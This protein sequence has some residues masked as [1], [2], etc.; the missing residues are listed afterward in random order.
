M[1]N[2][3]NEHKPVSGGGG[4]LKLKDGDLVNIRIV[5]EPV[6]FTNEYEGNL[7]TR[8]AWV[9]WNYDAD[10]A[11]VM[12]LPPSCYRQFY[13]LATGEWGDPAEY[14]V[15]IRR[16]GSGLE[17]KYYIQPKPKSRTLLDTQIE[18]AKSIDL[19]E[20]I[21]KSPSTSGVF[22]ISEVSD[23]DPI[24]PPKKSIDAE[25]LE[26]ANEAFPDPND[27]PVDM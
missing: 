7:S 20:Q 27:A 6:V 23:S 26:K 8:Y 3:Y 9:V 18:K 24:N 5:G 14:D 15:S 10:E 1:S 16:E 21:N 2:P 25:L 12:Q 22:F 19:K 13:D 11:Q 17:T 4:Y